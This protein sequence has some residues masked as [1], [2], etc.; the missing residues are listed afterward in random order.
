MLMFNVSF[1][2]C[3]IFNIAIIASGTDE[4][5]LDMQKNWS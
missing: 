2:T 4:N 5:V 1:G 3:S